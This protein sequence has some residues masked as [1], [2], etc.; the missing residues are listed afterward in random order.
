VGGRNY[1][2]SLLHRKDLFCSED[3][4]IVNRRSHTGKE[5]LEKTAESLLGTII[6]LHQLKESSTIKFKSYSGHYRP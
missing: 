3:L 5:D 6:G 1:Q 4:F 2:W